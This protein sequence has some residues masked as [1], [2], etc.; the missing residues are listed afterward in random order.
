MAV[1]EPLAL[2]AIRSVHLDNGLQILVQ[3]VHTAPLVSVWCW[4]RV[5][6][7]DEQPAPRPGRAG[8]CVRARRLCVC[9]CVCVRARARARARAIDLLRR[10]SGSSTITS[11]TRSPAALQ[12]WMNPFSAPRV[13]TRRRTT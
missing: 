9:V 5:G 4:Y 11:A 6:S 1:S 12:I 3:E 10:R 8:V 13:K 7:G 2:P